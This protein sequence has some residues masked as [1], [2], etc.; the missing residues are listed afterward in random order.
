MGKVKS[1]LK[2]IWIAITDPGYHTRLIQDAVIQ[3]NEDVKKF[4]KI[5]YN[6]QYNKALSL[7]ERNKEIKGF[8]SDFMGYDF[9]MVS[10]EQ[11]ERPLINMVDLEPVKVEINNYQYKIIGCDKHYPLNCP[12]PISEYKEY[13]KRKFYPKLGE[14]LDRLGLIKEVLSEIQPDGSVLVRFEFPIYMK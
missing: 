3:N 6:E 4:I 14:E 5:Q 2:G 8:S 1:Y 9:R 10:S 11:F 13:M 12:A 7:I